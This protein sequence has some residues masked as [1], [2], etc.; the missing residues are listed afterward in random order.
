[1][2]NMVTGSSYSTVIKL[3]EISKM[4]NLHHNRL[5]FGCSHLNIYT[6]LSAM[7]RLAS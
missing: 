6:D 7:F 4:R 5:A 2:V 3:N 1:M